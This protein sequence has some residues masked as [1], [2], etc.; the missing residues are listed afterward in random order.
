MGWFS[1]HSISFCID[2]LQISWICVL[3]V[4]LICIWSCEQSRTE[5]QEIADFEE[6]KKYVIAHLKKSIHKTE[7]LKTQLDNPE[8][9]R[10]TFAEARLSYKKAELFAAYNNIAS[11]KRVNGPP[12]PVFNEDNGRV[13]PPVGFQAIEEQVF[14]ED[15]DTALTMYQ[16]PITRGYLE[17]LLRVTQRIEITPRRF[18]VPIHQQFLRI[19]S[20][21]LTGFDTPASF[22]GMHESA[23]SLKSILKIYELS[24]QKKIQKN[25]PE[26]DLEFTNA[27]NDAAEYI[28]NNPD[29]ETFDR[30]HFARN[31]LNRLTQLWVEIRKKSG[32]WEDTKAFAINFDAPT[33]F[34]TNSF[35][36]KFFRSSYNDKPSEKQILLG[37]K[38][39]Y[40]PSLSSNKKLSCS[41][42]HNPD[43][44][45]QDGLMVALDKEGEP[46]ER[47]TPTL[48]NAVYQRKFFW[49][50]R[51]DY[52]EQQIQVVFNNEREFDQ[53]GHSIST[54][55]LKIPEYRELLQQAYPN[56]EIRKPQ[57]I[58]ALA[59]FT[60][61]LN[62][63]NSRFDRNMRNESDDFTRQE[64]LGMNLFM[65]K[66][67]CATCHFV[68]LFNGTVPPDFGETEKEVL[69][70]PASAKN[71]KLDDDE[72]FYWVFK[73]EVH[74]FMFKTPTVR[75]S[76]VTAPYMHNGAY[77]T[78]EEVMDF[79]NQGGGA[80]LG[81]DVPNQTLP[82]DS[83][84]LSE[85][86]QEAIIAFMKTLTDTTIVKY[87]ADNKTL[88][89]NGAN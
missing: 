52:L 55:I 46:L 2:M 76:E 39:F 61:T 65:G 19:Y 89:A 23:E 64:I 35:N 71:E 8:Q 9:A 28:L 37:E 41:S 3:S 88:I 57:I 54:D 10:K 26:L 79:Y 34:E 36:L 77:N 30:Y 25:S 42:C 48:I 13:L 18:F 11:V 80:G 60:S 12:L 51:S 74:K 83:L 15:I 84:G 33:F 68:P 72:G 47:N 24:L 17:N 62:G 16:T 63:F 67:L 66:A 43:K 20:L 70:I 78:L 87:P 14:S 45:F 86:E 21:G 27:I 1:A 5:T 82:F 32:L 53:S 40:D 73:E 85:K 56:K 49:D 69:G 44:S 50:G 58:R 22:L 31:H 6:V 38:L 59:A 7:Q 81:F 29:F 75:N 4:M